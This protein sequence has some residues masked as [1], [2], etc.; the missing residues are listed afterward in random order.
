MLHVQLNIDGM[1][2]ASDGKCYTTSTWDEGGRTDSIYQNGG[3]FSPPDFAGD[4][5]SDQV[6]TD[7][8]Y[9]YYGGGSGVS[10]YNLNGS[11]NGGFASGPVNG[12]AL[13]NGQSM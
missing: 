4:D 3:L 11:S 7:G 1:F 2:V 9:V 5:N 6:A 12:L 13:A 10:R 8:T